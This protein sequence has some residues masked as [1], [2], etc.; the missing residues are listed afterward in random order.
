MKVSHAEH[1][2]FLIAENFLNVTEIL[3]LRL[4]SKT[5]KNI[6]NEQLDWKFHLPETLIYKLK[7]NLKTCSFKLSFSKFCSIVR[8]YKLVKRNSENVHMKSEIVPKYPEK[9]PSMK[10]IVF[11]INDIFAHIHNNESCHTLTVIYYATENQI[12]I[13]LDNNWIKFFDESSFYVWYDLKS[14]IH[15]KKKFVFE[16]NVF[17]IQKRTMLDNE[18]FYKKIV[19]FDFVEGIQID[20]YDTGS[21]DFMN[22]HISQFSNG[23]RQIMKPISQKRF[24]ELITNAMPHHNK[25]LR[26]L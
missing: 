25:R 2:L 4:V 1:I 16:T 14:K 7:E 20:A 18:E 12:V 3:K 9:S 21:K 11:D 22:H 17:N 6:L 26:C 15:F 8:Y 13:K 23:K 5:M 24:S 10:I 19:K